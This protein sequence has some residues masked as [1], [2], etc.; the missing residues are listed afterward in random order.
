MTLILK[1]LEIHRAARECAP[2]RIVC[3]IDCKLSAAASRD[4]PRLQHGAAA[5]LPNPS[6]YTHIISN[7]DLP[8]LPPTWQQLTLPRRSDKM[9]RFI[10]LLQVSHATAGNR[11]A[12]ENYPPTA[13]PSI[14]PSSPKPNMAPPRPL[15]ATEPTTH[16]RHRNGKTCMPRL[17]P[18]YVCAH[19]LHTRSSTGRLVA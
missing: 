18:S 5:S 14:L 10:H 9:A 2:F 6:P 12:A 15:L 4:L 8:P 17:A 11:T 16:L 1:R 13:T 3:V 7:S 19:E